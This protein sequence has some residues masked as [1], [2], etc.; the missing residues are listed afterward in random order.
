MNTNIITCPKCKAEIPLTE[1][2]AQQVREQMEKEFAGKQRELL[3]DVAAREKVVADQ[4]KSLAEAQNAIEK[5][6]ADK[7]AT[8][9]EKLQ[10]EAREQAKAG[11]SVE[12]QDLRNQL[13]DGQKRLADAQQ[14]EL[15]LRKKQRELEDRAKEIELE[16]ARK[17]DAER[18]QFREQGKAAADAIAAR[19][20]MMADQAKSLAEAQN[21]IEKQVADKVATER[22]KLQAEAREQA[23]AG[24]SVEMQ[25]LR[26]QLADQQKKLTDAQQAELDLRKNQRELESRTKDLELEVARKLDEER[27]KIADQARQQGAEAERLK[28]ADKDN[29]I[30]VLQEQI[31]NLQQRAEQG[32]MQLQ[33]ETL[34]LDLENQLRSAFRFDEVIEVKKGQRGADVQQR[35]R[36]NNGLDCGVLLWEAKRAKNWSADWPEKLKEDQRE[37]KAEL[38]VIVTTCPPEGLRGIGQKDGVWVCEPPF[39]LG[40]AA[41]LRQGLLSTAA[42]RLQQANRADKMAM[43]YDHLCSVGFRQ[44]IEAIVESFLGMKEQLDAERRAFARQWKEREQQLEK[45]ITHT[46]MLYGGIQGIAGREALPEIK[47]L[48]LDAGAAGVAAVPIAS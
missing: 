17:L 22:E 13:A 33:G 43:L 4:A 40:L 24:I 29:L 8:E 16:V 21:A 6:V 42:Q 38:A 12:M 37:V 41:A 30:K 47:T 32:S 5:Q 20:K 39:A 1:A 3:D 7:V 26:N 14:S 34:E 45:A 11:L 15:D 28:L 2:M 46:A 35:V 25:N 19:E 44:H 31:A 10:A 18:A 36:T 23:K 27:N 9:R 48:Q